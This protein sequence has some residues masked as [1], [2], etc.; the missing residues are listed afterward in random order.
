[1]EGTLFALGQ[2]GNP[3]SITP[4]DYTIFPGN[5]LSQLA[6]AFDKYYSVALFNSTP[7]PAY[8]AISTIITDS[9]YS[10]FCP[11]RCAL[12]AITKAWEPVWTYCSAHNPTCDW[13]LD[14]SGSNAGFLLELLEPPQ[15]SEIP[16][17]FSPLTNLP[18]PNGTC[19]L[20]AQEIMI[21]K[22]LLSSDIHGRHRNTRR[23]CRHPRG[24]W[25]QYNVNESNR[26]L[27]GN[28]SSVGYINYTVCE[29]W[30]KIAAAE[31]NLTTNSTT[32][33]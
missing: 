4:T 14:T 30:D 5:N 24:P 18:L 21:S 25:P 33:P 13:E 23:W 26:L 11:T 15:T 10:C 16:L 3:G 29:L 17:V 19:S 20:D 12:E 27:V 31:V 2:V 9:S 22:A 7:F 1:M 6:S 8:Y 32:A 28:V